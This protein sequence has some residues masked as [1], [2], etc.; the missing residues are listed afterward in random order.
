MW[1]RWRGFVEFLRVYKNILLRQHH[2][3]SRDYYRRQYCI[4]LLHYYSITVLHYYTITLLHY[5]TITLL[6][7][8]TITLLHYRESVSMLYSIYKGYY[9]MIRYRGCLES[10]SVRLLYAIVFD[11]WTSRI[12]I[13]VVRHSLSLYPA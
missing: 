5:Y 6:L 2:I 4:T 9:H 13:I 12:P 1:V 7:Y 11:T 3:I 10:S 8:Y